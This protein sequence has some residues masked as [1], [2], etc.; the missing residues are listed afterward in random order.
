MARRSSAWAQGGGRMRRR[1]GHRCARPGDRAIAALGPGGYGYGYGYGYSYSYPF[2]CDNGHDHAIGCD[3]RAGTFMSATRPPQGPPPS[4]LLQR[5]GARATGHAWTVH[6]DARLPFAAPLALEAPTEAPDGAQD[7]MPH[8]TRTP[9]P[10]NHGTARPATTQRAPAQPSAPAPWPTE[11]DTREHRADAA[12]HH[13][14]A[15]AQ[16]DRKGPFAPPAWPIPPAP[17]ATPALDAQPHPAHPRQPMTQQTMAARATPPRPAERRA[18]PPLATEPST[19]PPTLMP[20]TPRAHTLAG[21]RAPGLPMPGHRSA[22]SATPAVA[23]EVHVHIGRIEVTALH[24]PAP[25]ARPARE[26]AQPVS[27]DTYLARKKAP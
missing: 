16:A 22:P 6:S 25:P 11:A 7:T 23:T 14:S 20:A 15:P 17:S 13:P 24:A 19:E 2:S 1:S 21:Q 27:L 26:R 8:A 4:G 12:G 5:L 9:L 3:C 18:D 10:T